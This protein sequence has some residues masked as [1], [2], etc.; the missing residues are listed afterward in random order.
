MNITNYLT[1]A[2]LWNSIK[3]V[4]SEFFFRYSDIYEIYR[5]YN[6]YARI[7]DHNYRFECTTVD[8]VTLI[9]KI[10]RYFLEYV[11]LPL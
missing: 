1:K 6:A 10:E 2:N 7:I 8:N 11:Y 5:Q 9:I 4:D 3:T